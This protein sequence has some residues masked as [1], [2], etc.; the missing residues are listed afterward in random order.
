SRALCLIRAITRTA[1]PRRRW[2]RHPLEVRNVLRPLVPRRAPARVADR[3]R[4]EPVVLVEASGGDP[5]DAG[6]RGLFAVDAAAAH[7]AEM[8]RVDVAAVGG[9]GE[10]CRR[11]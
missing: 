4:G 5:D 3:L 11:A 10:A 8:P 6:P 9:R 2:R 1:S 7:R